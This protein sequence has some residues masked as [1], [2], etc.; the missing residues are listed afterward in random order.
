MKKFTFLLLHFFILILIFIST[1]YSYSQF[2][3]QWVV[4]YNGIGNSLDEIKAI[5]LDRFG[6]LYVTGISEGVE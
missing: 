5:T 1:H 6:F 3:Q 2:T 4:R